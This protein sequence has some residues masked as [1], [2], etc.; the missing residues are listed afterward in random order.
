MGEDLKPVLDAIAMFGMKNFER[1][2]EYAQS[3]LKE[4]MKR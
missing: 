3:Q 4:N 1:S 2:K